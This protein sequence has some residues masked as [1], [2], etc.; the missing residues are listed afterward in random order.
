MGNGT[1]C[2]KWKLPYISVDSRKNVRACLNSEMLF[3]KQCFPVKPREK[4]FF[5]RKTQNYFWTK[6][7]IYFC[8]PNLS[9]PEDRQVSLFRQALT[10]P[11]QALVCRFLFLVIRLL[12][13][14]LQLTVW[15]LSI[16]LLRN[17]E[18][19]EIKV[20]QLVTSQSESFDVIKT[21]V[22]FRITNLECFLEGVQI[23]FQHVLVCTDDWERKKERG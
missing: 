9:T 22:Y 20:S 15:E 7:K 19:Q 21:K 23:H 4:R 13:P 10:T 3:W 8:F 17:K 16:G 5:R 2:K 6:L 18:E 11:W 12:S 1:F 14:F